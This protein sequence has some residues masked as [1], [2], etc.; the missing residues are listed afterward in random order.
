MMM[1]PL[2]PL[3]VLC[4]LFDCAII[5]AQTGEPAPGQQPSTEQPAPQPPASSSTTERVATAAGDTFAIE[6]SLT[7]AER[8]EPIIRKLVAKGFPESYVRER[9]TDKRTVFIPKL[10]KVSPR[11]KATPGGEP[12]SAYKWVNT[13]ESA[14][15]CATFIATYR[16]ILDSANRR[17]GV[18]PEMIAA[19]MRTE[20]Q[21]GKVTGDYHVFSVFAST[22]LLTQPEV[23]EENLTNARTTM[24]EWDVDSS[25]LRAQEEYIRSRSKKKADWA[26]NELVSLMKM[27]RER[28][29][30]VLAIYGSWAG[31]FG[32]SQFLPSS[33]M[34]RAVDGNG[35]GRI[36]LFDPADAIHS[37]AN[38]L[39]AAG[40]VRGNTRRVKKALFN[41]NNSTPYVTS[42]MGLASRVK[43]AAR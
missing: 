17:F 8:Y 22:A 4:L 10:A 15:A 38:Y 28:R 6:R 11:K 3:F 19:L 30:D 23:L 36:S 7:I 14:R 25:Y 35:D 26:L 5:G 13:D 27:E 31:A 41:Y 43:K 1:R 32:W 39:K 16:E 33:Y 9:F 12:V 18:E 21:H 20:T 24:A 34:S 40:Y 37:V 29:A 42:I 2:L